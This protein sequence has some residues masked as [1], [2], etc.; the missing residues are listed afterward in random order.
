MYQARH[1]TV[2]LFPERVCH[3]ARRAKVLGGNRYYRATEGLKRVV[4]LQEACIV[5]SDSHGQRFC[6]VCNGS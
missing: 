3:L 4:S 1:W 2:V 6:K 5:R